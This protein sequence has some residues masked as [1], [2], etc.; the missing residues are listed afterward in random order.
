MNKSKH[1][2]SKQAAK[3]IRKE[4]RLAPPLPIKREEKTDSLSMEKVL[5]RQPK[6]V[7]SKERSIVLAAMKRAE[8]KYKRTKGRHSKRTNPDQV[9][10]DE[11]PRAYP[12]REGER[13]I[14]TLI[15]QGVEKGKR[16]TKQF[17]KRK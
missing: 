10:F 12:H 4:I 2:L 9:N 1:P 3:K 8:S 5:K 11:S 17:L 14:K 6:K 15:R 16:M 7:A 13:W